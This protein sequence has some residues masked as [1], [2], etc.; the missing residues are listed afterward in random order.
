MNKGF[1]HK[2]KNERWNLKE[3]T[4]NNWVQPSVSTL[5]SLDSIP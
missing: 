5:K 4:K 1:N 3:K 2:K